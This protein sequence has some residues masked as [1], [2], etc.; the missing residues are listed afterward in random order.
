VRSSM[1]RG[2]GC[3]RDWLNGVASLQRKRR[4]ERFATESTESTEWR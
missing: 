4:K 1:E 3:R 2:V